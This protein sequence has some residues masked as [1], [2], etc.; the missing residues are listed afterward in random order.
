MAK[1]TKGKTGN[2]RG[3]PAGVPLMSTVKVKNAFLRAFEAAGGAK[4]LAEWVARSEKN[5]ATFYG[6]MIKLVPREITGAGGDPI[7]VIVEE[8]KAE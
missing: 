2:P 7:K 1:F 5:R 8:I 4:A 6:Y 3:R